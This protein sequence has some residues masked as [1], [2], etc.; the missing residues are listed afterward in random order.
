MEFRL[1]GSL[2][3]CESGRPIALRGP[4]ER[5]TLLAL[6]LRANEVATIP[7]GQSDAEILRS[8]ALQVDA[9]AGLGQ[10]PFGRARRSRPSARSPRRWRWPGRPVRGCPG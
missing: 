5:T 4:R 7:C 2:E 6:L 10:T 8:H 1:L 9:L 3:V